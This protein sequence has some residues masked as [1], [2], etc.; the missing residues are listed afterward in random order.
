[1]RR[2]YIDWLRGVAVLI[3]MSWHSIDSWTIQE[4]RDTPAFGV[5]IFIAG[6]AAPLFLF[7]AGVSLPFAAASRM[8]KGATRHEAGRAL[9]RR[10]WEV[11]V[12]AHLFRFQSFLLN[13]HGEW[14]GLFKPDILNILGLGLVLTAICWERAT[15]T[16]RLMAWLLGPA[17]V[18]VLVLTPWSRAWW[19][20]TL[21]HPRFEAYIRPVG[22]YGV[23][24]LFPAIAYVLLGGLVGAWLAASDP[25][26]VRIHRRLAIGGGV[27]LALGLAGMQAAL[28]QTIGLDDLAIVLFR[29]GAMTASLGLSWFLLRHRPRDRWSPLVVFGKTSLFVYWVHVEL[30][31]GVFSYP[32][33]H[34]LTLTA[35]VTAYFLLTL[36]MLACA[37]IWQRRPAGP[38]VPPHMAAAG[39]KSDRRPAVLVRGFEGL[40]GL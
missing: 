9:Q 14:S 35:G 8:A 3:M 2:P 39:K 37:V 36:F 4:G 33:H 20:P 23:F 40:K 19:W 30:A 7:L 32:W 17:V 24:T 16:R 29:T 28:P 22:N 31:Y 13:P 27:A 25:R 15:S 1:M 11:F 26:D 12:I 21:L 6:W 38:L 10:G 18:V 5:V 34:T